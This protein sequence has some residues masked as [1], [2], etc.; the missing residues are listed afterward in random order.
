MSFSSQKMLK[1]TIY[2]Y[3]FVVKPQHLAFLKD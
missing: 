2:L 3:N 1:I